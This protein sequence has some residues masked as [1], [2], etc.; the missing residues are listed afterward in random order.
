MFR[1]VVLRGARRVEAASFRWSGA[2]LD[3]GYLSVER[4]ILQLG[5]T[6]VEGLPKTRASDRKIWLDDTTIRAAEGAPRG[7]EIR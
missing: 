5:G 2:D 3:A 4:P 7:A 1:I 6:M